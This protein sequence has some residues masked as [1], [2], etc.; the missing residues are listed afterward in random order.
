MINQET[1]KKHFLINMF[2]LA[3]VFYFARREIIRWSS[4]DEDELI[5]WSLIRLPWKDFFSA[6][7]HDTQ[8]PLYYSLLKIIHTVIPLR[9]DY[10]LRTISLIFSIG[11]V[12]VLYSY[13]N[14]SFKPIVSALVLFGFICHPEFKYYSVYARPYP[15]LYFLIA[16]NA[17][18]FFEIF[19]KKN[20]SNILRSIFCFSL[21]ALFLTHYLGYFYFGALLAATAL[22]KRDFF[23]GWRFWQL[24]SASLAFFFV[25]LTTLYQWQ[26]KNFISWIS[27]TPESITSSL[28]SLFGL[29]P[30]MPL[31]MALI[32]FCAC[33]FF[34]FKLIKGKNEK[35]E[36]ALF[37]LLA[38]GFGLLLFFVF[39]LIFT[40]VF[41]AKYLFI[42]FPFLFILLAEMLTFY[43]IESNPGLIIGFALLCANFRGLEKDENAWKF[44]AKKFL[45]EVKQL[46]LIGE[47]SRILC[48]TP[49]GP[50]K[51][52]SG[53]SENY[54]SR[55]ICTQYRNDAKPFS[56]N[57]FDFVINLK[58]LPVD[59]QFKMKSIYYKVLY[60]SRDVELLKR[61]Q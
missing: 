19:F 6:I 33:L 61:N 42:F 28:K 44:D 60:S 22:M 14:K 18:T 35:N 34:V 45:K 40:P 47:Q 46:N 15:L 51:I 10:A 3:L 54:F 17:C 13:F 37:S 53:Y 38:L 41:V 29:T 30:S 48:N 50:H 21:M 27:N 55:D 43:N 31:T 36:V 11:T 32:L 59:D 5:T 24:M 49:R 56:E 8:Q 12:Q 58:T 23:R 2:I 25:F 9:S 26:F 7:Y 39:S 16:V 1:S 52:F 4:L 57:D 20:E